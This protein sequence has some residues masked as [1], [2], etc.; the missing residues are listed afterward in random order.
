MNVTKQKNKRLKSI[1]TENRKTIS[2]T[3][4][5]NKTLTFEAMKTKNNVQKTILSTS[6]VIVTLLLLSYTVTARDFWK[7]VLENSSFNQI[8]LAMSDSR[9]KT[10]ETPVNNETWMERMVPVN[11]QEP[12]MKVEEWMKESA[13]FEVVNLLPETSVEQPLEIEDWM[14]DESYFEVSDKS[15]E[16]LAIEP[17]MTSE[18]VWIR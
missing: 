14:K 5:R 11:E 3:E 15:E 8:A 9:V 2:E 4:N 7:M 10:K 6:A 13:N 17:W 16:P 1:K 12:E 18:N